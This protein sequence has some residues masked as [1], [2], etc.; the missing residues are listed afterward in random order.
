MIQSLYTFAL[1]GAFVL[2]AV[3]A[4]LAKDYI[5]SYLDNAAYAKAIT[6]PEMLDSQGNVDQTE[7]LYLSFNDQ[8]DTIEQDED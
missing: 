8:D 6:H 2:G 5:D 1:F 7:L 3:V 4:W